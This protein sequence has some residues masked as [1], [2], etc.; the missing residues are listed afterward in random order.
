MTLTDSDDES[1]EAKG[2]DGKGLGVEDES[3]G[4]GTIEEPFNP[5]DIDVTTKSMTVNLLLSR[6]RSKAIDLQPEFQRRWGLWDEKRQSRL[7]ESLLLR[8]P[9]PSLYAAEDRD[10]RW[11]IVDGIQR[12]STIACFVDHKV[13][14]DVDGHEGDVKPLK[15][16]G[17]EYLKA[18][19][20]KTFEQL[21][22]RFQLRLEEAEL[23]VHLIRRGTPTA[24]KFNVFARINTGG[25]ALSPQEL[26]HAL[27]PGP[28]RKIL[29]EWAKSEAFKRA[30]DNSVRSQRMDDREMVLRFL[31]YR[32][33]PYQEYQANDRE[34]FL[35]EAMAKINDLAKNR[36]D[37]LRQDFDAAM[38]TAY[39]IFG[40]DAFRKRYNASNQRSTINKAL[41][42]AISVGLATLTD[43]QRLKLVER[44]PLICKGLIDLCSD[45]SFHNAISQGVTEPAKV[46]RRFS[47]IE[48][49]FADVASG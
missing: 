26:R 10:E 35:I 23:V 2:L 14:C 21:P 33:K 48:G 43:E 47:E 49:L 36:V 27:T 22:S 30:T 13:L 9:L 15:L 40:L 32:L 16:S 39:D 6:V 12:L 20:G 37:A 8:I 34:D 19:N 17:L 46:R 24:V 29:E 38:E 4:D 5:D 18:Y 1:R 7:I 11:E 44:R 41:F 42:E 28:A 45:W 25:V 31:A 3:P